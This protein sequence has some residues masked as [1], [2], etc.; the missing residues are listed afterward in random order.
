MK[1]AFQIIIAKV[2]AFILK[3]FIIESSYKLAFIL[4]LVSSIFPI[5]SIYFVGKMVKMENISSNGTSYFSFAL[6][7]VAFI[8]YFQVA[9]DSFSESIKRAQMA[10]CLEAILSSQTNSKTIVLMSSIYSFISAGFHL[11][12]IFIVAIF[13]FDFEIANVNYLSTFI[14]IIL[15]LFVF[16]SLGI[17][18]AAGTIMF[19]QGEPFGWIFGIM[20]GLLGG[21][22]FPVELMPNWLQYISYLVPIKYSLD[23]L[24]MSILNGASIQMLTEVL[25]ILLLIALIIFPLSLMIFQYA[26]DTGKKNGTLI[27]Y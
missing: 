2:Q 13:L 1:I 4:K 23:A 12:I 6:I 10:G 20:S 3:D 24:R 16:V 19:K 17:F 11:I 21:V 14:V 18:S 9:V 22:L 15:S 26:V 25:S 27:Q 7:G 8:R 5:V